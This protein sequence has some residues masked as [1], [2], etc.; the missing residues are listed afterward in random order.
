MFIE[1]TNANEKPKGNGTTTDDLSFRMKCARYWFT[2]TARRQL[3]VCVL[4]T[5]RN[6]HWVFMRAWVRYVYVS[7]F[8]NK[9]WMQYC[10]RFRVVSFLTKRTNERTS[11]GVHAFRVRRRQNSMHILIIH[12]SNIHKIWVLYYQATCSMSFK[13][14]KLLNGRT[15]ALAL[16]ILFISFVFADRMYSRR[17]SWLD[18]WNTR[19]RCMR[20]SG[21]K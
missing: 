11:S 8:S 7:T 16:A 21:R 5:V 6:V 4:H 13:W 15:E 18:L 3:F 2:G 1:N 10:F 12:K 9:L 14:L 19:V 17:F 20:T